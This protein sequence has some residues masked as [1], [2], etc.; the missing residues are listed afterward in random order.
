MRIIIIRHGD[1]DYEKDCLTE[2]GHKQA[3]LAAKRL[4]DEGIETIY[5][6]CM[7]R[8][9][10]TAQAFSDL[11]GIGP[12][13][14]LDFMKEIRFG[15][16]GFI[17]EEQGNPWTG[18]DRLAAEGVNIYDIAWTELPLFKDN[19]ATID[20]QNI[21]KQTDVWLS[22]LG[23]K[24]EGLYYRNTRKDEENHTIALFCHGG[25][26]TAMLSRILNIPFPYLCAAFHF[27]HTAIT[28]LRFD[29]TPG[30]LSTPI[31]ELVNDNRHTK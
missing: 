13:K 6:S 9:K 5:S 2:L 12:V 27:K 23:Y 3:A 19:T 11:S 4:M 31:L 29:V 22:E 16:E 30:K 14:I 28:I 20:V 18:V 1:P 10:Q 15:R 25:S 17:Y 21:Q 24:R 8:A 7:G 26:S